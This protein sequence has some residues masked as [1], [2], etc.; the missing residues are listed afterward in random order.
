MAGIQKVFP[1]LWYYVGWFGCIASV[2]YGLEAWSLLFPLVLLLFLFMRLQMNFSLL[3]KLGGLALVGMIFDGAMAHFGGVQFQ[4]SDSLILPFWMISIWLL[5]VL[6]LPGVKDVFA[7]RLWLASVLGFVF[8][9]LSYF[10]G[11]S[12]QVLQFSTAWI[13]VVYGIFWS[14]F[15]PLSIYGVRQRSEYA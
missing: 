3:L 12:L 8:G 5:F 7:E 2:G 11:V 9:P 14:L 1:F 15:F 13:L 6:I 10:S 4:S